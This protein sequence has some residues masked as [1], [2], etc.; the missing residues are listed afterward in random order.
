MDIANEYDTLDMQRYLLPMLVDID[1]FFRE[2]DIQYS[3]SD[4]TL[5]G[6]VRHK[7]YI[8]WDDDID[9]SLDRENFNKFLSV[10]ENNLP[11]QYEIIHEIWIRR[12]SR[13]DNPNKHN[14]PPE[15]CIDLF[16]FDKVP[17]NKQKARQQ[18]F[19]LKLL[20]GMLK[21]NVKYEGFSFSKKMMLFVTHLTGKFFPKKLKQK[22]YD[23]VSQWGDGDDKAD[24]L[25]RFNGSFRGID[26]VRYPAVIT[27]SYADLEFEGYH[28]MA[29]SGWDTFLKTLYGD[30]MK[31][32]EKNA[33]ES[34]H[35]HIGIKE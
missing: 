5:L 23:S 2:N 15:G 29:I 27:D 18:L 31:I 30:Y 14:F 6:A 26:H 12:I 22:W 19:L 20:Q 9:L 3:L 35:E 8:P 17:S 4:G 24:T 32:P 11:D 28:F 34:N 25:A 13:K 33:R 16:I 10:A 21:T 7:G 1:Q